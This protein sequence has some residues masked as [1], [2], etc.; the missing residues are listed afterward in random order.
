MLRAGPQ[1]TG[2]VFF[3][4]RIARGRLKKARF[5][6]CGARLVVGQDDLVVL[7]LDGNLVLGLLLGKAEEK[8]L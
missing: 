3:N 6:P 5:G 4:V 8:I 7:N 1:G 2:P